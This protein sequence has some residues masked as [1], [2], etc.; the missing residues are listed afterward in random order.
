MP[1]AAPGPTWLLLLAHLVDLAGRAAYPTPPRNTEITCR[2]LQPAPTSC[3]F[4]QSEL[5]DARSR[6]HSCEEQR[7][8][9]TFYLFLAGVPGWVGSLLL[10]LRWSW[11]RC[12][13]SRQVRVARKRSEGIELLNKRAEFFRVSEA[14][15]TQTTLSCPASPSVQS[16]DVKQELERAR[17]RARLLR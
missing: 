1:P 7:H 2:A 9:P 3:A 14:P 13:E 16:D 12:R 15:P 10:L 11:S 8:D 6:L 5:L 4:D 17:A